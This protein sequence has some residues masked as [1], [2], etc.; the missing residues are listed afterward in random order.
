M[1]QAMSTVDM[2]TREGQRNEGETITRDSSWT[3]FFF[4]VIYVS[5]STRSVKASTVYC[6]RTTYGGGGRGT[7]K[8]G[9]TTIGCSF[10]TFG[11]LASQVYYIYNSVCRLRRYLYHI[12][13]IGFSGIVVRYSKMYLGHLKDVFYGARWWECRRKDLHSLNGQGGCYCQQ[14]KNAQCDNYSRASIYSCT[15]LDGEKVQHNGCKKVW[16]AFWVVLRLS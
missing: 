7:Y 11:W 4:C 12:M 2:L 6:R 15:G 16:V 13:V 9:C 3:W 10:G 1:P 8:A 5:V 14:V